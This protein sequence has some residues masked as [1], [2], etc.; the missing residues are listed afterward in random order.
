MEI[1][2]S[3]EV[4]ACPICEVGNEQGLFTLNGGSRVCAECLMLIMTDEVN[5]EATGLVLVG[6][7]VVKL[8]P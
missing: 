8:S 5:A 2:V 1:E 3:T 7:M 4:V 6:A